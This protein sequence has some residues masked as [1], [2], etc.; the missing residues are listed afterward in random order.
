MG[1]HWYEMME[2][3][4]NIHM[5]LQMELKLVLMKE[6]ILGLQLAVMK[7][8]FMTSLM[9]QLIWFIWDEKT[10]PHWDIPMELQMSLNLCLM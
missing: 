3:H 4:C 5:E 9:V 6:L 7:H 10:K 1:Y 8:I 2:L